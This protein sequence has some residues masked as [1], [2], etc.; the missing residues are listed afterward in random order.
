M[1]SW[2]RLAQ[3]S[4][5]YLPSNTKLSWANRRANR[6]RS[7]RVTRSNLR[8][9]G[10]V[11]PERPIV[12]SCRLDRR[13]KTSKSCVPNNRSLGKEHLSRHNQVSYMPNKHV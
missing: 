12:R 1:L 11:E 8:S 2:F 3:L 6:S 9:I 7:S 10:A 4:P 13:G 5:T